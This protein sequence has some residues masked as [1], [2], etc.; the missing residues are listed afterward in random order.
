[1][2]DEP[3]HCE[4]NSK[5]FHAY[6][7]ENHEHIDRQE[8]SKRIRRVFGQAVANED[9]FID[10]AFEMGPVEGLTAFELKQYIRWVADMRLN[11]LGEAP[12]FNIEKMPLP[13]LPEMLNGEEFGNFFETRVTDYSKGATEGDWDEAYD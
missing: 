9:A 7:A 10:L 11:Q 12:M 8:L 13:W 1:M 3:L 5:L 6:V 2:R 4:G